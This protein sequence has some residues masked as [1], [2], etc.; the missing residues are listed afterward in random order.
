MHPGHK[1]RYFENAQ[2]P[3]SWL[4]TARELVREEY[5][6][7]YLK[8]DTAD[9]GDDDGMDNEDDEE[10][11][12]DAQPGPSRKRKRAEPRTVDVPKLPPVRYSQAVSVSA[13][14]DAI[15]M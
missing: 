11:A 12:V 10:A 9:D 15:L 14:I 6:S 13:L 1:M 3:A 2:W 4:K 8:Q 5:D 7:F